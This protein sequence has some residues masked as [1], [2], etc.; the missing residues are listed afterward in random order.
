MNLLS[1]IEHLLEAD[2]VF[3]YGNIDISYLK[4]FRD[5]VESTHVKSRRGRLCVMLNTPGGSVEAAEKMVDV[6][7]HHYAEVYF[8]IP[9]FAMSAGTI[10]VMSGDKIYMDYYSSIGPI[11]PQVHNGKNWVPALGY[12]DK[13][14]EII[15][16]SRTVDLS[17]AE[18]AMLSQID[19]A[20]MRRYEQA[21]DLSVSLLKNWLVKYKFKNW[22]IHSSSGSPVEE[23]EKMERAEQIAGQLGNNHLWHSHGRFIGINVVRDVLGL[24]I[25]D[26]MADNELHD[27]V[28]AYNDLV[29]EYVARTQLQI[30]MHTTDLTFPNLELI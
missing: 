14:N 10:L 23:D 9:D 17:P 18:Y 21:R 19:L 22:T 26:I 25:E 2:V 30:F 15:E 7:R 1:K 20:E 3:Y 13:V 28:R 11:D 8:V 6:M 16:N 29:C 4:T 12:I 27:S 24:K 5:F